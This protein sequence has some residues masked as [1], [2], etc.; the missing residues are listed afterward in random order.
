MN[1]TERSFPCKGKNLCDTFRIAQWLGKVK[2]EKPNKREKG[3]Q[4]KYTF[5]YAQYMI[6]FLLNSVVRY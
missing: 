1:M 3:V 2:A 6:K 5:F 4:K